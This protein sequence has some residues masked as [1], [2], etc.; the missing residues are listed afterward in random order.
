MPLADA[1][2]NTR[3]LNVRSGPGTVYP[4]IGGVKAGDEL[5]VIGKNEDGSWLKIQTDD[6]E[7]G[8][9][10]A[11]L[12]QVYIDLDG[13]AVA[14]APPTP[15]PGPQQLLAA[16]PAPRAAAGFGYGVQAHMIG[17]DLNRIFDYINGMGFNWVKQQVEWKLI[18][19][20]KGQYAWGILDPI[21]E[22]ANARGVNLLFSVVKAPKWARPANTDFSVE[23]PPANPQDFAD[24]MAAM[25]ARYRGRVQAYEIWNEQNLWY[26]WGNEPLDP[27][28]YVQLLAAAYRA[29]KAAD[30]NAI[31]VSGALTPTGVND[32]KIAVD[33]AVYL[34]EMYKAG[35]ARYCDAIGA[36][37]S[38]YNNPP[39]VSY[40]NWS[41]PTATFGAKGHRSWFFYDTMVTYRNIMV[42]YG[43]ARKRIWPTEFGWASV[44]GLGVPPAK[45]YEYAADN[46]EAE[47]AQ[48][49]VRAFQLARSW[50]W[51]GPMFVWNLN[52][53]PVTGP[54]DEKAAFGLV[55][56]DWSPRPAYFALRDMPK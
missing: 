19:P 35:L 23:G 6:I 28:R 7:E 39:D 41:D 16:A 36:H 56:P 34:E 26:E 21:V 44:E 48:F 42:R 24:F 33:D 46:T 15:T 25:A 17:E 14:E 37:P 22:M 51:V 5:T 49:L 53:G 32:W 45:G 11:E 38:G 29:I 50:G 52:F 8:W 54:R 2:V 30:P 13:V 55:R 27:R 9:V 3:A 1:V 40:T 12:T 43:D 18:E 20:A 47:Q 10:F 31:V 4:I